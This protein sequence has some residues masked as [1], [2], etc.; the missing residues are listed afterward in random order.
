MTGKVRLH[1]FSKREPCYYCGSPPPSTRE[2]APPTMMFGGL[3]CDRITVPACERHNTQKSIGDRAVIT[4]A[5]MGAYQ[6]WKYWPSS[7]SLSPN[8]IHCIKSIE[9]D[10]NWARNEVSLRDFLIDPPPELNVP[11]PYIQP[12]VR[13]QKWIVHLTAALVWSVIGKPDSDNEWDQAWAW[14]PHFISIPDAI[15]EEKA[16]QLMI[17]RRELAQRLDSFAWFD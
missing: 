12:G 17:Q 7:P 16:G 4:A 14:S 6:V 9:P 13:I 5:I 1:Q 15:D 8:V 3:P 11:L 10:F 2:H